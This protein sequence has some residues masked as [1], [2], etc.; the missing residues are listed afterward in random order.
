MSHLTFF[1]IENFK[2][3]ESFE[4]SNIG[5]FNIIVGDNNVGKTT[6]LEALTVH[7]AF[8]LKNYLFH[9]DIFQK[10]LQAKNA[11]FTQKQ[12]EVF[13]LFLNKDSKKDFLN[14]FWNSGQKTFINEKNCK[15]NDLPISF[16]NEKELKFPYI[17]FYKAYDE[18]LVDFYNQ[19]RKDRNKKRQLI[20]QLKIFIPNIENIE[21]NTEYEKRIIE[22]YETISNSPHP[23]TSYGDGANKLLRI[24]FEIATNEN[25][26]LMVDEI[27][28]GIHFSRFE[29]FWEIV[30]TAAKTFNV[31]LFLTTHNAECLLYFSEV[32]KKENLKK[33]QKSTRAYTLRE[34]PDKKTVKSYLREFEEFEYI[35]NYYRTEQNAEMR[36]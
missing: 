2:R 7:S 25:E 10:L 29:K 36:G 27:E 20:E 13:N 21:V 35:A 17:P 3:F 31:Q 1:K 6:L 9:S 32:L 30:I 8:D 24:L 4:L 12:N 26:K 14:I 22:V 33:L 23:I 5:Q 18:D 28:T 34:L 16:Q 15:L 19:I 11:N